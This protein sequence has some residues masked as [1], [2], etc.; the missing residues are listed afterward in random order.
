MIEHVDKRPDAM[1]R[2]GGIWSFRN[3]LK[4]REEWRVCVWLLGGGVVGVFAGG[5]VLGR[6]CCAQALPAPECLAGANGGDHGGDDNGGD[7][8]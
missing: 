5:C 6:V 4:V 3:E 2:V 8:N 1:W 7:D